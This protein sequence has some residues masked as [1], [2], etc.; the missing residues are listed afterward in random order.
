MN[1]YLLMT[2]IFIL[3]AALMA[4]DASLASFTLV[5]WFTGLRWLRV[6]FITLGAM[7]EVLFGLRVLFT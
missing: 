5:P 7:T 4:A 2:A 1:L 3:M 6:H